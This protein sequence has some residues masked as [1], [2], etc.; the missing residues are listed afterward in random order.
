MAIR[1]RLLEATQ[2]SGFSPRGAFS[3]IQFIPILGYQA[4]SDRERAQDMQRPRD[5]VEIVARDLTKIITGAK[6]AGATAVP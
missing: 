4:T 5:A 2:C 1:S 6:T 3:R